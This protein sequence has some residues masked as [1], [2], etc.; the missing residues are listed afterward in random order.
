MPRSAGASS[1]TTMHGHAV[2]PDGVVTR[3]SA[4]SARFRGRPKPVVAPRGPAYTAGG[5]DAGHT[6]STRASAGEM[7]DLYHHPLCPHSRF[8]RLILG[9]M[10][11]EPD[12]VE[13]RVFD[14]RRD[15]LAMNPAGTTPVLVEDPT[16][17]VP[18]AGPIAEYLDETRGA[19]LGDRRLV[20]GT[21]VGRVEMRRL[22]DWWNGKFFAEVSS[23][24]ITEKV[25]KRFMTADQGGGAPDMDA[26]RVART[27]I[28]YHMRYIGFL[29]RGRNWM[30]GDRLTYADLAAAA[31][32]SAID[33]L[34][35]VP[36]AEDETA[37]TW[38]G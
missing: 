13:E 33:F 25:Y 18:G 22:L 38:Y 26:V 8:I 29:I 15:F 4:T 36:W 34:G 9:E 14:R 24:L 2:R 27:N 5:R 30:A 7:T 12:L 35:D 17:P 19:A 32:L 28:R 3:L 10:G 1:S 37:K 23:H 6:A 11:T 31:H 20:P 16:G 21:A